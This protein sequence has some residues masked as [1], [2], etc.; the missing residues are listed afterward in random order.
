MH[1]SIHTLRAEGGKELRAKG[2][3]PPK[4]FQSTPSAQEVTL[5]YST[6][7]ALRQIS[8]HPFCSEGDGSISCI[9]PVPIPISIHT[10]CTEGDRW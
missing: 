10:F 2:V 1:V 3:L 7:L 6:K 4:K 9:T 8:P 5:Y